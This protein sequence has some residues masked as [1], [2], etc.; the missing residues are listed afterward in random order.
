MMKRIADDSPNNE[1]TK[2][3]LSNNPSLWILWLND[4]QEKAKNNSKNRRE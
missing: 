3:L 1:Y 4:L 2:I